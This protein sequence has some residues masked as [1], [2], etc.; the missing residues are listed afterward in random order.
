MTYTVTLFGKAFA[1]VQM[2]KNLLMNA[3]RAQIEY[4]P[5]TDSTRKRHKKVDLAS[6]V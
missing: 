4:K 2:V 1:H 6:F 3:T 5:L